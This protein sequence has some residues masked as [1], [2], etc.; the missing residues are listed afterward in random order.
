[1]LILSRKTD[2]RIMIG[3]DVVITIVEV[4]GRTVRVGIEAPQSVAVHREEIYQ[5]VKDGE[6]ER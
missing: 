6:I 5:R 2:Q 3:D 1:M 4:Q